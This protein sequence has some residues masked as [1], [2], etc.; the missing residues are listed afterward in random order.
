VHRRNKR[1]R[2]RL[3]DFLL[4]HE[5]VLRLVALAQQ[6]DDAACIPITDETSESEALQRPTCLVEEGLA[7]PHAV[8]HV[9]RDGFGQPAR[10]VAWAQDR[11]EVD[12]VEVQDLVRVPGLAET[13]VEAIEDGAAERPLTRMGEDRLHLHG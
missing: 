10:R 2:L 4:L 11:I 5:N 12:R 6:P 13:R 1:Q 7:Q 8:E 3:R 9:I